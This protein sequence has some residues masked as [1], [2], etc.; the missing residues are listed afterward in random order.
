MA[1]TSTAVQF[2]DDTLIKR[3]LA[4]DAE[5]FAV[6]VERHIGSI[7]K[8]IG[9]IVR[10]ASDT[11][12][13]VQDVLLKLWTRLSTFRSES[14]FRTWATRVAINEALMLYRRE[15]NWRTPQLIEDVDRLAYPGEMTDQTLIRAEA[16]REVRRAVE[17]LPRIYSSV[18]M[19]HALEQLSLKETARRVNATVPVVKSRLFRGRLMLSAAIRTS[20]ASHWSTPLRNRS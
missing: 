15:R 18:L 3:V 12:D 20:L 16:A 8:C 4:G 9:C 13:V 2:E 5:S 1:T 6:L 11:D 10:N 17:C 14:T 7:R 19:L